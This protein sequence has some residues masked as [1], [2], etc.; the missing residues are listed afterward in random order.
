M[1]FFIF[2]IFNLWQ[3]DLPKEIADYMTRMEARIPKT[4]PGKA[5]V[6][7]LTKVQASTRFWGT[8][9]FH[10]LLR[11]KLLYAIHFSFA[12]NTAH[13]CRRVVIKPISHLINNT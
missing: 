3:A 7:Y 4:K 13:S 11:Y 9:E 6:D 12:D 1:N 8:S 5:T 10:F 2:I